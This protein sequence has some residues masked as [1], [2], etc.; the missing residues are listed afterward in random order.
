MLILA[1]DT[2]G[3]IPTG[4]AYTARPLGRFD[5]LGL[6]VSQPL[7]VERGGLALNLRLRPL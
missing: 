6:R 5:M 2:S 1:I 4:G 7:R 3:I